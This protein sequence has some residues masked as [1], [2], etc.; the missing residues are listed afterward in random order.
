L[1]SD[2]YWEKVSDKPFRFIMEA[3]YK[4]LDNLISYDI[5]NVRIRY[6]GENDASGSV[7]GVDMRLNGEFVPGVESWF[8]VSVLRV[9]ENLLGVEHQRFDQNEGAFVD[10]SSVPR[11]TDQLVSMSIYFQDYLPRNENFKINFLLSYATGLPFGIPENNER[12]KDYVRVDT[13]LS[14]QLWDKAWKE[15]KP[16]HFL[17]GMND[18]WISLEAFNLM[19]VTNV[20]SNT[21]IKSI[22]SQ[23]FAVPNFLT[24]RRINLNLKLSF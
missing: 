22:F 8:N 21:W 1:A 10:V 6:S 13:G 15:T 12:F 7:M 2:F 19:G 20:S 24:S 17:R 18:A 23:Q 11:P 16:N 3:Y 14:L 4:D 9:K 5:D